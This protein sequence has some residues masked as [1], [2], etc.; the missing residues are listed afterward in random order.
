M[1]HITI[2]CKVGRADPQA[3]A[4]FDYADKENAD[5][6][7]D[8]I[9]GAKVFQ[10]LNSGVAMNRVEFTREIVDVPE[11]KAPAVGKRR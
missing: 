1:K 5:K 9:Q 11:E 2:F 8:A 10:L 6:A 4:S 3:L 7:C